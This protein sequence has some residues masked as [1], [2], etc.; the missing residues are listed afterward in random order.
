M[1]AEAG[2]VGE[3]VADGHLVRDVR[4]EAVQVGADLV[5]VV[6]LP[7]RTSWWTATAVNIVVT[8]PSANRVRGPI[9]SEVAG[10]PA[11]RG[12]GVT[13]FP[14][15]LRNRVALALQR[16]RVLLSGA[17]GTISRPSTWFNS[18]LSE[19]LVQGGRP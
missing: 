10:N 16:T 4:R 6:Q 14:P 12:G 1:V 13:G 3:H 2:G 17:G 7:C 11:G 5:G 19:W 18:Q 8:E 9:R 15:L